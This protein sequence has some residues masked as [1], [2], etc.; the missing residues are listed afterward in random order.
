MISSDAEI[1]IFA[2]KEHLGFPCNKYSLKTLIDK[3][4]LE[5]R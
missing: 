5:K 4:L 1:E 3:N 2:K